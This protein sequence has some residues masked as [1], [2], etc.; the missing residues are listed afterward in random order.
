MCVCELLRMW[1]THK[2]S[3]LFSW[4]PVSP[5]KQCCG[6]QQPWRLCRNVGQQQQRQQGES[7]EGGEAGVAGDASWE[8]TSRH[9]VH[10]PRLPLHGKFQQQRHSVAGLQTEERT[11]PS[12]PHLPC[13]ILFLPI[14]GSNCV[15]LLQ[16]STFIWQL[17]LCLRLNFYTVDNITCF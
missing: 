6:A 13:S 14:M 12:N 1:H 17:W 3:A 11:T 9:C 10:I 16:I 7:G 2:V 15:L 4:A 8:L 5:Q